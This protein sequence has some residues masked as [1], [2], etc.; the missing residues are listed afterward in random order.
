MSISSND[1]NF[2]GRYVLK[3]KAT[4]A[5][6][7]ANV[8]KAVKGDK[9]DFFPI[10]CGENKIV[11]VATDKDVASLQAK[12]TDPNLYSDIKKMCAQKDNF[13]SKLF[14]RFFGTDK[15]ALIIQ[16][17]NLARFGLYSNTIDYSTGASKSKYRSAENFVD[18]TCKKYTL[19]GRLCELTTPDGTTVQIGQD[20]S[21]TILKSDGTSEFIPSKTH[22]VARP[23]PQ[24]APFVEPKAKKSETMQSEK[25]IITSPIRR[26]EPQA[27]K[28]IETMQ[29]PKEEP[30]VKP[31]KIEAPKET[32]GLDVID[33]KGRITK[34]TL[35]DGTV[36]NYFYK[37]KSDDVLFIYYSDGRFESENG[38]VNKQENTISFPYRD[39][40]LQVFNHEGRNVS[41]I[42]PDGTRKNFDKRMCIMEKIYPD[43]TK[44]L[45]N[46]RGRMYLTIHPDGTKEYTKKTLGNM[47]G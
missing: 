9:V 42:F 27:V 2:S 16:G 38:I 39:G 44:E 3:G 32:T 20:G 12:K 29:M 35:E 46:E 30:V 31:A 8:I 23:Q 13:L 37:E 41:F 34:R 6:K 40:I 17:D 25:M 11:V 10:T 15:D 33:S 19:R 43:G 18:G 26:S 4:P 45:F 7:A 24:P 36:A 5:N 47:V 1:I 22:E 21:R 14:I 28:F